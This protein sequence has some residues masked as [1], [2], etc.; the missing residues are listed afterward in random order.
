[1]ALTNVLPKPIL[2]GCNDNEAGLFAVSGKASSEEAQKATNLGYNCGAKVAVE[3][4][5][6]KGI[7]TW[8][9]RWMA[10]FA[11]PNPKPGQKSGA[12]HASEIP[13]VFGNVGAKGGA[14][15]V[16]NQLTLSDYMN[17]MWAEFAKD[18]ENGLTKL[19][20]PVYDPKG[21]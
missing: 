14:A 16:A 4:R 12:W 1:M 21:E 2:T 3:G 7:K 10:D 17:N 20:L 6:A 5:L 18:P 19:K 8:R 15:P 9:Y 11:N 13:S